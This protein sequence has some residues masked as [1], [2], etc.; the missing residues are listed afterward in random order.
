MN[1]RDQCRGARL[2]GE[3]GGMESKDEGRSSVEPME[4]KESGPM[5]DPRDDATRESDRTIWAEV[6]QT[7]TPN[8]AMGGSAFMGA[9]QVAAAHV[10]AMLHSP[11]PHRLL[12][13][14]GAIELCDSL[15]RTMRYEATRRG[16]DG[17]DLPN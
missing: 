17:P 16:E 10:L 11:N 2:R 15:E 5:N 8:D 7:R 13:E 1:V 6:M 9:M 3:G 14:L 4:R 12:L